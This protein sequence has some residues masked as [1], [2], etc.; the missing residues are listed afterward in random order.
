MTVNNFEQ[1]IAAWEPRLRRAFLSAIYT[2]RDEAQIKYIAERL[3]KGD[4]DGA[5]EAV[6][7]DPVRF[8]ALDRTIYDAF[9][10][11]GDYTAGRV[12]VHRGRDGSRLDVLFDVRNVQAENW[13][14]QHSSTKVQEIS[15]DQR[16][17]I[18]EHLRA[19][20]EAGQNP[21]AVAL[22]LV[23]RIDPK[24]KRR[25]G[26][27]I[28]LASTQEAWVRS[29]RARLSRPETMAEALDM[30]LRDKRFDRT[31]AKAV[32]DG[33]ALPVDQVEAM[34]R[35]YRNRALKHRADGIARTEAMASMHQASAEAMAQNIADGKIDAA[36]VTKIWRTAGDGRV[37]DSHRALSG[38]SVA[39]NAEFI[40]P[41]GARLRYP[42]D[43]KAPAAEIV[44]CR[45][46]MEYHVD[47]LADLD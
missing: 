44:N 45:C 21:R 42:G 29:Y 18:R 14:R 35:G 41:S 5:M 2:V 31:V 46:W 3:E 47:F 43:P 34:V 28:G 39:W 16:A 9:E 8:R 10:A 36:T 33:K 13:I 11:A 19:G 24:T 25:E 7:I 23:G 26:G 30:K 6:G 32:K 15:A 22:D 40:S 38:K 1:L 17:M 12:P 27:A 20:M 37:R 4:V